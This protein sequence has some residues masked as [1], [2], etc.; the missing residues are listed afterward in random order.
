MD[1]RFSSMLFSLCVLLL[2]ACGDDGGS[3]ADQV[4]RACDVTCSK[5]VECDLSAGQTKAQCVDFCRTQATGGSSCSVTEAQA[6]ACISAYQ[7]TTCD[8]LRTGDFPDEC[9][10]LCPD[11][12][13]DTSGGDTFTLPDTTPAETT[14]SSC[15][16][17]AACCTQIADAEIKQG[18]Q[19][20]VAA[21]QA[22]VCA[23]A[24]SGYRGASL[25]N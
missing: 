18:C 6:N 12:G 20:V 16:D 23:Q 3:S 11:Q 22:S 7:R 13:P 10:K 2:A 25:C 21:A 14:A 15:D 4:A 5:L 17:L 1:F 8:E 19:G 9:N 24:L